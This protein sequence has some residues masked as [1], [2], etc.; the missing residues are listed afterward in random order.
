MDI[1]TLDRLLAL[2]L[3][4]YLMSAALGWLRQQAVNHLVQRSIMR[5]RLK[6]GAKLHSLPL[7]QGRRVGDLLSIA[8]N[9]TDS[10]ATWIGQAAGVLFTALTTICTVEA[11]LFSV[12]PSLALIGSVSVPASALL[13]SIIAKRSRRHFR[14]QWS[15]LS[16]V[17]AHVEET[18]SAMDLVTAR[19]VAPTPPSPIL[20]GT[21]TPGTGRPLARK[22]SPGW[23]CQARHSSST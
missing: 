22:G 23:S 18:V 9:D 15:A 17:S 12:S 11:M 7:S 16:E 14:G 21:T 13:V 4:I 3:A 19:S 8:T 10:V 2:A 1:P 20:T 6:I 5:L